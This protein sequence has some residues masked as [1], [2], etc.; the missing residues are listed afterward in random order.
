MS[1][2]FVFCT[3]CLRLRSRRLRACRLRLL[4]LWQRLFALGRLLRSRLL[5]S[6]L[7]LWPLLPLLPHLLLHCLSP[8]LLLLTLLL[9][10]R[11][12]PLLLCGL[13]PLLLDYLLLNLRL[14]K[15]SLRALFPRR[16]RRL[17]PGLALLRPASSFL[18]GPLSSSLLIGPSPH[19]LLSL[20]LL[21]RLLS[22]RLNLLLCSISSLLLG[23]DCLLTR[24]LFLGLLLLTCSFYLLSLRLLLSRLAHSFSLRLL[25]AR[26]LGPLLL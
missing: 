23:R 19:V 4:L 24:S 9:W 26:P 25:R 6:H 13:L 5:L 1:S 20:N 3:V 2:V 16:W 7:H 18:L 11:L 17:R 8:R 22:P 10:H 14:F 12:S 15:T 21:T